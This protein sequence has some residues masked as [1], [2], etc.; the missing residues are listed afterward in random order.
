M[1]KRISLSKDDHQTIG[2]AVKAAEARTDAE[3]VTVMAERSDAYHDVGLHYAVAAVFLLLAT[4]ATWPMEIASFA[5]SMVI[6][7][8]AGA[9]VRELL[10]LLLADSILMFLLVRYAL[11]WMPLRMAL[12]PGRTKERRVRRRAVAIFR[13]AVEKRTRARTGVLLYLSL[14]EHRAEIVVDEEVARTIDPEHWGEAMALLVGHMRRGD[15]VTGLVEAID[16]IGT[17]LSSFHPRSADDF[18]ELPDRLVEL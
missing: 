9:H 14:A 8:G 2:A 6:G 4:V 3:I 17:V 12:T 13:A 18:N 7:W 5:E 1:A 15:A 11:A 16:R 10:A